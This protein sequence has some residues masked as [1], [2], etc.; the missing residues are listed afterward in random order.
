MPPTP[1]SET[2]RITV[3]T[4]TGW[5]EVSIPTDIPV[6]DMLP[7]LVRQG[8][9]DDAD[10]VEIG[11]E[12]GGWVLQRL[13]GK[14]LDEQRTAHTL[15]LKDGETLYLRPRDTELPVLEF[16]DVVDGVSTGVAVRP[17]RWAPEQTRRAALAAMSGAVLATLWVLL[18]PGEGGSRA[19]AA[20]LLTAGL[21]LAAT[22]A[23]RA[24]DDATAATLLG[25]LSLP[26]AAV[27]GLLAVPGGPLL[28][29]PHVMAAGGAAFAVTVLSLV[30]AGVATPLFAGALLPTLALAVGGTVTATTD[31]PASSVGGLVAGAALLLALPL[32]MTASRLARIQLPILPR[33]PEELQEEIDPIP[34]ASLLERAAL[35]DHYLTALQAGLGVTSAAALTLLSTGRFWEPPTLMFTVSALLLLRARNLIGTGARSAALLPGGYGM[36]LLAVELAERLSTGD[37][38]LWVAGPLALLAG[39]LLAGARWLPGRRLVPYWGRGGDLLESMLGCAMPM[40]VFAEL[41]L[42]GLARSLSG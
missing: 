34:S 17:G 33:T 24:L 32:P 39:S 41:H 28:S 12:H 18:L 6:A 30:G 20:G 22:A 10:L 42:Y 1:S 5:I 2:C 8:K 16:D 14:A 37:R 36:V 29:A 27:Y 35:A 25:V 21:V 3:V 7:V 11:L 31:L 38:I 26:A 9:E 19:W 4:P 40:F 15:G 23:S 13:G